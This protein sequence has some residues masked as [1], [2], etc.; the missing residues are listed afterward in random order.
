MPLDELDFRLVDLLQRDGRAT[1]LEL[2]RAVG[3]S[4]PAVAE[5]IRK[6]EERGVI[7]GYAARVDATKLGKDITAFI[8]VS[9]EHPKYFEGFAKK[10]LALPDV[11]ECHRVAGQDSYLVKVKTANTRTLDSLLVETLRTIAGVTRT[12]TTI[13]LSS[14]KEDTH[15]RVPPELAKESER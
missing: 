3:L 1:Q 14:I 12:Q 4:Q 5:R 9:I 7:T 2:S 10:V 8:G 6:L 13:V 11:L 15:V